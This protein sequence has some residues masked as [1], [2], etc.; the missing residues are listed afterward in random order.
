MTKPNKVEER[1][2]AQKFILIA[3]GITIGLMVLMYLMFNN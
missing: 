2:Q 1:K 3:V